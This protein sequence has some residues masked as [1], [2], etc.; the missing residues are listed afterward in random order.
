[1]EIRHT[2]KFKKGYTEEFEEEY[3]IGFEEGFKMEFKKSFNEGIKKKEKLYTTEITMYLLKETSLD[4]VTKMSLLPDNEVNLLY[5]FMTSTKNNIKQLMKDLNITKE[6]T[7]NMM[8]ICNELNIV[9]G[10]DSNNK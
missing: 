6:Y 5:E 7:Y 2:K 8:D 1:M 3:V 4:F 10:D 9:Y